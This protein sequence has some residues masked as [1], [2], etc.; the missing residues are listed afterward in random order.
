MPMFL[1]SYAGKSN[2]AVPLTV[3]WGRDSRDSALAPNS[4][5]YQRLSAD[6]S[7]AGALKYIK[8]NYQCP[9]L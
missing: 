1:S 2:T 6:W 8:A 4:G 9:W 7:V 5:R 3:G